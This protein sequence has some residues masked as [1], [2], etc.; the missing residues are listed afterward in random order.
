MERYW[1]NYNLS[2]FNGFISIC[3]LT[4][5]AYMTV[6][7]FN[8]KSPLFSA[9]WAGIF[10]V[11]P[12][13]TSMFF[14]MYTT[15]Y[16][17]FAVL[18]SVMSVWITKQYR[19]GFLVAVVMCACSLGIYQAYFPMTVSLFVLLL[20]RDI[21]RQDSTVDIIFRKGILFLCTIILSLFLYFMLLY[22]CLK[23]YHTSLHTYQG[24]DR[25][26]RL[27]IHKL[28]VLIKKAYGQILF[29]P[30]KDYYGMSCTLILRRAI[31][32]LA[33]LSTGL[34][35]MQ[36]KC[37]KREKNIILGN[38]G[39]CGILPIALNLI[40]I[41]CPN[42]NIYTLMI[43][44][45]VFIYLVPIL[46]IDLVQKELFP[47]VKRRAK[48]VILQCSEGI[49]T[50]TLSIVLLNY[51]YLSN[52]NY[53]AMYYTTQQTNNYLNSLITQIKTVKGY[54]TS[55]KWAF[56]GNYISDPLCGNL[57]EKAMD[58]GGTRSSL[59]NEYSRNYFIY[60][61]SGCSQ[62]PFVDKDTLGE[63]KEDS[64]IQEMPCYPNDGSIMVYNDIVVVKL[65]E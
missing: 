9:L 17:S 27:D 30:F 31:L 24:V 4:V 15:P 62:I 35:W 46:L 32:I 54:R 29:I 60:H 7:I 45:S 12:S 52:K 14:F 28:P 10:I 42:S 49:I 39:L 11:S 50:I 51:I 38:I 19:F 6:L 59:I 26:G 8:I 63:L 23:F 18:L 57:W 44:A 61:Y 40:V 5:A 65:G 22:V 48:K 3:I 47:L 33:V 16:Y 1:G 41:M 43:Y 64:V 37:V 2:F 56:I 53:T 58:Y 25:I 20:I 34:L 55:M 36:L 21:L 13:V